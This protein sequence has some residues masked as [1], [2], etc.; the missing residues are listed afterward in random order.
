MK[1][2]IFHGNGQ[3]LGL[4]YPLKSFGSPY[5]GV[6]SERDHSILNKGTTCDAAF[7]QNSLT[8]CCVI[9][10]AALLKLHRF[11]VCWFAI[12]LN[13]VILFRVRIHMC[14]WC[15]CCCWYVAFV[16]Q[17]IFV[18]QCDQMRYTRWDD[19]T[20]R[21]NHGFAVSVLNQNSAEG[22]WNGGVNALLTLGTF[23]VSCLRYRSP[24][25]PSYY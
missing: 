21:W 6:H 22:K 4:P 7:C 1:V 18:L 8:T 20:C 2:E 3:L 23:S 11:C 16:V 15:I 9:N 13:I 24:R 5:R 25:L 10:I 12:S 17:W 19:F 14:I